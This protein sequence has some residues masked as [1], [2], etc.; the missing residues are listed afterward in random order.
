LSTPVI[1]PD[2]VSLQEVTVLA[3]VLELSSSDEQAPMNAI[4]PTIMVKLINA[5]F[6]ITSFDWFT[7]QDIFCDYFLLPNSQ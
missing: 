5:F 6:I 1:D 7:H 2:A 4:M 3:V